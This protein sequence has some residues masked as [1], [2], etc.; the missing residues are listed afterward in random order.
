MGVLFPNP[1]PR[2]PSVLRPTTSSRR[3]PPPSTPSPRQPTRRHPPRMPQTPNPLQRTHRLGTP[4]HPRPS[5]SLTFTR[6]GCLSGHIRYEPQPHPQTRGTGRQIFTKALKR[7]NQAESGPPPGTGG[8]P[9]H[10]TDPPT[11]GAPPSMSESGLETLSSI[12]GWDRRGG[13]F[14]I[15]GGF[16][17]RRGF[18]FRPIYGVGGRR[19]RGCLCRLGRRRGAIL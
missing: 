19:R 2:R 17:G 1:K 10:R 6:L 12:N 4:N 11:N 8:P 15:H 9:H 13:G 18:R 3:P 7:Q 14:G 5:R 16:S